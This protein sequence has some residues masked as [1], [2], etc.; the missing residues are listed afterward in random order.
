[1]GLTRARL[2]LGDMRLG[3]SATHAGQRHNF[4][5][6]PTLTGGAAPEARLTGGTF[7]MQFLIR[8]AYIGIDMG[9]AGGG[10]DGT[11]LLND[12]G[13]QIR[14]T[15]A[16][17]GEA[18]I[19]AGYASRMGK[20]GVLGEVQSGV[21]ITTVQLETR[22]E[23]SLDTS[24]A[25]LMATIVKPQVGVQRWVSPWFSTD[26]MIGSDLFAQRDLSLT[27]NLTAHSRSYDGL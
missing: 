20:W 2:S 19:V 16:V 13:L 18:K 6:D 15:F 7:G 5:Y 9:V 23:N 26:L 8:H 12:Q 3:G 21:R 22:L 27:F 25:T 4:Q 17:Q 24:M 10:T 1:M 11:S 14:S